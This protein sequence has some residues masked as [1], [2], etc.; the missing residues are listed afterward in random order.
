MEDFKEK[1]YNLRIAQEIAHVGSFEYY[2]ANDE[3]T[4]SDEGLRICGISQK[5]FSGKSDAIIRFIHPE[6]REYVLEI[7]HRAITEKKI[8]RSELRIIRQDGEERI[9]DFRIGPRFDEKRQLCQND[10]YNP[11]YN[12]T[13][14]NREGTVVSELSRPSDEIV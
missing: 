4:C 14:E 2:L 9:V 5:E 12:R 6:E 3:L 11:G 7:Y 10:W 13:Q 8:K 1:E